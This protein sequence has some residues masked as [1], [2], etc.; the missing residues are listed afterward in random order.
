MDRR[1]FLR[2]VSTATAAGATS[3]AGGAATA[4]SPQ[5]PPSARETRAVVWKVEGYTCITCATGLEV[6]LKGM[7]GVARV[8]ASWPER[9]VKIGFDEHQTSEKTLKDFI[10]VCGFKVA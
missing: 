1:N 5:T 4:A 6:M 3:I 10:E 8:S 7:K 2:R 9:N